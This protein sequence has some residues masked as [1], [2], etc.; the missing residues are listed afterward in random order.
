M[1]YAVVLFKLARSCQEYENR[2]VPTYHTCRQ[3]AMSLIHSTLM[4][5]SKLNKQNTHIS[6]LVTV[7]LK[8]RRNRHSAYANKD[9][10]G[11][12]G[13]RS[14]SCGTLWQL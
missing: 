13:G 12:P 14:D 11:P 7:G 4:S 1:L 3:R 8:E 9:S 2:T 10:E 5:N 6:Q